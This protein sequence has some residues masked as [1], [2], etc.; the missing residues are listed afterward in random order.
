[1]CFEDR[2]FSGLLPKKLNEMCNCQLFVHDENSVT[3][4]CSAFDV[5]GLFVNSSA[6]E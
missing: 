4:N 6:A 5:M 2:W 1:M 3:N